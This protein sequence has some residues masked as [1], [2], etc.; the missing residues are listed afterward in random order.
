MVTWVCQSILWA[1]LA[2]VGV[3]CGAGGTLPAG[4]PLSIADLNCRP[5]IG[6]LGVPL[7]TLVRVH[8]V[9]VRGDD[10][11][12][13]GDAGAYLVRV[14]R[15]DDKPLVSPPELHFVSMFTEPQLPSNVSGLPLLLGRLEGDALEPEKQRSLESS[16]VG[17]SFDF[18]AYEVGAFDGI[19]SNMNDAGWQDH[20]FAFGTTLQLVDNGRGDA[21]ST[22]K[23]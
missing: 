18:R 17:R 1:S 7:G 15:V 16:F 21:S 13:K 10:T 5:V 2:C 14:E 9:V 11:R 6:R 22:I 19:P 8:V 4:V 20:L 3:G 12:S 23:P